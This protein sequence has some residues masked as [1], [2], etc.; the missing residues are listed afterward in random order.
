[1]S[2]LPKEYSYTYSSDNK[3]LSRFLSFN[4]SKFAFFHYPSS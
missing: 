1:M 4:L 3:A 2:G